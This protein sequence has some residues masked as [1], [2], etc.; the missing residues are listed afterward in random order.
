M[1]LM[2]GQDHHA[3]STEDATTRQSRLAVQPRYVPGSQ[4]VDYG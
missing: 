1:E 4:T 2:F 3:S